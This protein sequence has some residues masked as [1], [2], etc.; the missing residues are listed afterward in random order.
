MTRHIYDVIVVGAGSM[1]ISAGYELARRGLRT[2]LIDAFDPPHQMGSHH[3]ESRLIRHAYSGGPA[4]VKMALRADERWLELE[5]LTGEKLLERSGVLNLYDPAQYSYDDRIQDTIDHGVITESLNAS[6][7]RERWSGVQ[8]PES[9]RA[10]YETNA[11][12]LFS[13]RCIAAYK[14]LAL[15]SGVTLL[16]HTVVTK[17]IAEKSFVSVSTKEDEFIAHKVIVSA[18]A[19]FRSFA[20]LIDL[21]IKAVRKV[22]GWFEPSDSSFDAGVFPGFTVG[23]SSGGYYGFPSIGGAGVKIG[24]HDTGVDWQEG[25]VLA[26]FGAYPED[27][28]DLR[29]TL[30]SFLPGAAGK[31]LQ[32]AACKYEMT[33]DEHFIIDTHPEHPNILLAGGFSGHGF[34]FASVVGEMLADQIELGRWGQDVQLFSASRFSSN[35]H[36]S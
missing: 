23:D 30:E 25:E 28:D 35:I 32:G 5:K 36:N 13:E 7:I 34:K 3:G 6:Q 16:T 9:Y 18:G 11:G 26:P 8:V 1:G 17:I 27:E 24:R 15:Q 19:W 29:S 33:P 21:P 31:L 4:Y 20:S 14:K 10:M 22:V 2:L 12:Y